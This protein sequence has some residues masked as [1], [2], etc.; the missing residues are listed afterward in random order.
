MMKQRVGDIDFRQDVRQKMLKT[1][2]S[3]RETQDQ[4]AREKQRTETLQKQLK[5]TE[6]RFK[7]QLKTAKD[8]K[9]RVQGDRDELNKQI[10]KLQNKE[11][12]YKHE[13][14]QKEVQITKL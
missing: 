10:V 4:L 8:D 2:T 9:E 1:E 5:D 11:T 6:N 13:L 3:L 12:Q 7:N 14:R